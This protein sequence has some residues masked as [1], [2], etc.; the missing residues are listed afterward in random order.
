MNLKWTLPYV[1]GTASLFPVSAT[2]QNTGATNNF[3]ISDKNIAMG[4]SAAS[5]MV[6]EIVMT[7]RMLEEKADELCDTYVS[8]MLRSQ[9]KLQPLM[10]RRGYYSAVRTELPGAPVGRHCVYGQY[11]HLSRALDE[12]GD[13]LEIIPDGARTACV[14]FKQLMRD[15]YAGPEYTGC[16]RNGVM[17][18]TD[19]AY[20]AALAKYL[21]RNNV[22]AE[23]SDSVRQRHIEKFA[24]QNFSA[25]ELDSG[26]ILIVPRYRGSRSKFHAIMYLGRGKVVKGKFVPD[27][28][29]R[30]IYVGHNRENIGD[31]FKSYD[32]SNVF[33]A[34]TRK[35]ARIEYGRELERIES[36]DNS[37][38]VRF[39]SGGKVSENVLRSYPR[40]TLIRMA[41][42]KYFKRVVPTDFAPTGPAISYAAPSSQTDLTNAFIAEFKSNQRS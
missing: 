36:M 24:Q 17:H 38:L 20:N 37:Q 14:S 7:N 35:I 3:N 9:E 29:G 10:G 32:S 1:L 27:K 33:A 22:N 16:I 23:T 28:T 25:D 8:N 31:L 34:D 21:A 18:E 42:N 4:N 39:L 2:A 19:S 40:Q 41:R 30:H 12:M 5:S 6:A 11:T 15:K 26:A 13:T